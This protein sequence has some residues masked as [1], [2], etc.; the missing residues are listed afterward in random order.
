MI[1][2]H[3]MLSNLK[4]HQI[5]I[6]LPL[7][8]R[9][10]PHLSAENDLM[11]QCIDFEVNDHNH[12]PFF[13]GGGLQNEGSSK[14]ITHWQVFLQCKTASLLHYTCMKSPHFK[15]TKKCAESDIIKCSWFKTVILTIVIII[16]ERL[17]S[18]HSFH[19][20]QSSVI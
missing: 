18:C 7:L 12:L 2:V 13:G 5:T 20:L 15:D 4:V 14:A 9:G 17:F 6:S 1:Q 19:R 16:K 8:V 10:L 11:V 3:C